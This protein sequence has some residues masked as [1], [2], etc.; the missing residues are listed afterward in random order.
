MDTQN[1]K[2]HRQIVPMYHYV[3]LLIV[4]VVVIGS[5]VNAVMT[6]V[7]GTGIF[8][9]LLIFGLS[10]AIFLTAVFA[11]IFALKAQDRAICAE[12]NLRHF[13]KTGSLLDNRLTVRQVIGLRFASDEEYLALAKKAVEEHLSEDDIKKQIRSWRADHYRA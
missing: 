1:Y 6:I 12:E 11:R 10:A 2:T 4:L 13:V 8:D 3:L 5:F 9:A 7:A